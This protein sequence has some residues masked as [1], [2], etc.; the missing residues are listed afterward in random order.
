MSVLLYRARSFGS[1]FP[2]NDPFEEAGIV[3]DEAVLV[4]S[5][6]GAEIIIDVFVTEGRALR[7]L[8]EAGIALTHD[9][10]RQIRHTDI[11]HPESFGLPDFPLNP[12]DWQRIGEGSRGDVHV[13][14]ARKFWERF[15]R[16]VKPVALTVAG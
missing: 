13:D 11:D 9:T 15:L 16:S 6:D 10:D 3:Q 14:A 4:D 2:S 12:A 5:N 8:F 7:R 1:N